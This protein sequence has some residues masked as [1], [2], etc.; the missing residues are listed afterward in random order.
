MKKCLKKIALTGRSMIEMLAVI[1]IM[2]IITVGTVHIYH[3]AIAKKRSSD[4]INYASLVA[5]DASGK[6][7]KTSFHQTDCANFLVTMKKPPVLTS[8]KVSVGGGSDVTINIK[9]KSYGDMLPKALLE[10]CS[11]AIY[12]SPDAETLIIG[13]KHAETCQ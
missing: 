3:I 11:E 8:C 4:I 2:G 5:V 6:A 1:G 10:H 9:Y 7:R 12:V 13:E